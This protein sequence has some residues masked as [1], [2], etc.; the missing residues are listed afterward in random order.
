MMVED[1]PQYP[2][3][4]RALEDLIAAKARLRAAAGSDPVQMAAAELDLAKARQAYFQ[5][6]EYL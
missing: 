6:A 1:H 3:W 5:I 4:R 2:K